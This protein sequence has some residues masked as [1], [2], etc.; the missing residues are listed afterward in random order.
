MV[1]VGLIGNARDW[2]PVEER[3]VTPAQNP[4]KPGPRLPLGLNHPAVW[5]RANGEPQSFV[6]SFYENEAY[7]AHLPLH[8]ARYMILTGQVRSL[9]KAQPPPAFAEVQNAP[10][11][12]APSTTG[13]SAPSTGQSGR[14]HGP[15]LAP[16]EKWWR[17]AT[18]ADISAAQK[19]A[20][21]AALT[22]APG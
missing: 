10:V 16:Y 14:A 6:A 22:Q 9:S 15:A 17:V 13:P 8:G 11:P 18:E 20:A 7:E 5:Y 4:V 21:I 3:L 12:S 1:H 2:K 19:A